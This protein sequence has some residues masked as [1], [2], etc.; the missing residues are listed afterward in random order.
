MQRILII[1]PEENVRETLAVFSEM[2]GYEPM[3]AADATSCRVIHAENQTCAEE[4]PCADILLIN[5]GL[6]TMTG[7]EFVE[8]QMEKGCKAA[9]HC[10]AVM[11]KTL[12]P[13]E[14][15]ESG[16][17]RPSFN[18]ALTEFVDFF[19]IQFNQLVLYIFTD[20]IFCCISNSFNKITLSPKFTTPESL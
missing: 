2:L 9:V 3:F 14:Y 7:L 20:S 15:K 18:R 13:K 16:R 8:L 10:K 5:Q 19:F 6:P 4:H 1:D 17:K 11:A 12:T